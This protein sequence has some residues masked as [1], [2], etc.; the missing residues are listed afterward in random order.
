[1]RSTLRIAALIVVLLVLVVPLGTYA[2]E[3]CPDDPTGSANCLDTAPPYFVVLNRSVEIFDR[4]GTGCQPIILEHPECTDCTAPECTGIDIEDEVCQYLPASAGDELFVLC[5]NCAT[6]P[7]GDWMYATYE[8]DGSGGCTMTSD[9]FIAGLP[10]G[11]GIDL[12]APIIV[13]ALVLAA[14]VLVA[15]GVTVRRRMVQTA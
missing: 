5:C 3:P 14:A 11:T 8:L 10:P 7:D 9:G 4:P 15:G 6:D 13:G 2:A 1:M 12:P